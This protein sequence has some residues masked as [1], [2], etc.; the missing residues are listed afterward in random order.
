MNRLID[1][2]AAL[3]PGPK[4]GLG[5]IVLLAIAGV[6]VSI[7]GTQAIWI[8][9]IGTVV[10]LLALAGYTQVLRWLESRKAKPMEWAI[11]STAAAAPMGIS[12]AARR[13]RLDDLRRKFEE[14]VTKFRA[15]GKNLYALPW[16][17]LVGEPG[18]GKTEA[19]RH[20]GVGFPPGLQ[21]ELQGAGGTLNMNWWFTNHAVVIDTAGRLMFEEIEPGSTSEWQE[22]LR[23]LKRSRPTCPVNGM[24]LVI[25]AE[26]LIK[27]SAESITRKAGK[28][29]RQLDQIQRELGVRFPVFVV[30]TKCDLINGF[31]E[32][33]DGL[34]SPSAQNQILGWSNPAPLD[35]PFQPEL[36]DQHLAVVQARLVRRRLALLRDPVHTDNPKARRTD[37]VDALYAFPDSLLKL[38]PRLRKY[39]DT[40][41]VAGEWAAKPLF[42]R[43]IYFTSSMREGSA[44][45]AELAEALGVNV[46]SLPEGRIWERDR[47][48]FLRDLFMDKV[49]RERGLVT[50]AMNT[51]SL[52]RTRRA[53]VLALAAAGLL[54]I[55]AFTWFGATSLAKSAGAPREFWTVTSRAFLSGKRPPEPVLA[56]TQHLLPIVS[57][58]S[59]GEEDFK[60]RGAPGPDAEPLRSIN[61]PDEQRTLG[62]FPV[63][64]K[65]ETSRTLGVPWVFYPVAAATGDLRGDLLAPERAQAARVLYEGSVLRPLVE[66]ARARLKQLAD[67]PPGVPPKPWPREATEALAQLIRVHAGT[68]PVD[69]DPLLRFVLL[70]NDHYKS[71]GAEAHVAGLQDA[72]LWL[73]SPGPGAQP[74]P[75]PLF[76]GAQAPAIERSIGAMTR[77]L[78]SDSSSGTDH[79]AIL[80]LARA[81]DDFAAAEQPLLKT[82]PS[83]SGIEAAFKS[84]PERFAKLQAAAAAFEADRAAL[85]GRTLT[86]A[87]DEELA[88]SRA[89]AR[90]QVDRILAE[91]PADAGTGPEASGL[92]PFRT[93]LASALESL[94]KDS[95]AIAKLRPRL[96]ELDAS[97]VGAEPRLPARFSVYK[98]ID[99]R[100]A[101]A[102]DPA[103]QASSTPGEATTLKPGL[104]RAAVMERAAG[105]SA[106]AKEIASLTGADPALAPVR[107][108]AEQMLA[109]IDR[110]TQGGLLERYAASAPT[111]SEAVARAVADHAE[112]AGFIEAR[113]SLPL[114]IDRPNFDPGYSPRAAARILGDAFAARRALAVNPGLIRGEQAR[115]Q[116]QKSADAARAYL[117]DYVTYWTTGLAE[118][119]FA[120]SPMLATWDQAHAVVQPLAAPEA[121]LDPLAEILAAQQRALAEMTPIIDRQGDRAAAAVIDRLSP[122][123]AAGTAALAEPARK[124]LIERC[125]ALSALPASQSEATQ[126]AR[127]AGALLAPAPGAQPPPSALQAIA[128]RLL[129]AATASLRPPIP[130]TGKP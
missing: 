33:F 7:L 68:K 53:A 91:I 14:G 66:S 94:G 87:F 104:L 27:D 62:T 41:F 108:L 80:R 13:A 65:A 50:R 76:K 55:G 28:I 44:L 4:L 1:R 32:F 39:L 67:V 110:Q 12:D 11:A 75:P 3:P 109:Q 120:P 64:L 30:V 56:T 24:L 112:S 103:T 70:G 86:Q 10:V 92:I 84:W 18:S 118:R 47:S 100:A 93:T 34:D 46:D 125:R 78:S 101:R 116:A 115:Q 102:A 61:L 42:L 9:L 119:E 74:W 96:A 52:Q 79:A 57:K 6:L 130:S 89:D 26:S 117:S 49:F 90:K 122:S 95:P 51:T 72:L 88:A 60:Y 59:L 123:V 85:K 127:A 22:F 73:Y 45:D 121:L 29:A 16:Y 54:A 58:A 37:Q 15:A 114:A 99:R 81:A 111:T 40:I 83:P 48:Y 124:R 38:A 2:L 19:V 98:L 107:T 126:A 113:P 106:D 69:I 20:C 82:D 71:K 97:Q 63:A 25:P 23:L 129:S 31:R 43:G 77:A 105:S 17:I 128:D 5:A 21:D 8:L 36:V 35:E